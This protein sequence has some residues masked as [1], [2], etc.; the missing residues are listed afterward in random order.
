[1]CVPI[2]LELHVGIC[3]NTG[4]VI[5][6]NIGSENRMEYAAIG[7]AVN[8][9]ARLSGIAR[10]DMILI[11][12]SVMKALEGKVIARLI[13]RQN[14]KGKTRKVNFYVVQRVLDEHSLSW[15]S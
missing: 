3:I 5:L 12:E 8:L 6:G 11:S 1:M 14:I 4:D 9:A 13:P 15:M 2:R 10:P 7:D